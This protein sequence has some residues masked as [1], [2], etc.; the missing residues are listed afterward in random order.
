MPGLLGGF[1]NY[2]NSFYFLLSLSTAFL[3][4]F[5]MAWSKKYSISCQG[6]N[7]FK[8]KLNENIK[9]YCKYKLAK[10][11]TQKDYSETDF[12]NLN[13][14]RSKFGPYLAGLIEGD[15][16]IAV[17]DPKNGAA[18][19]KY[20]P[21]II[22]VFKKADLPLANYLQ[23]ITKCGI[24][25][26]KPERGYVL[27]QIQDI[28]SVY[29]IIYIINGFMRTPK[30]EALNKAIVWLNN[31][32]TNAKN[33]DN[34]LKN[35]NPRINIII[36]KISLL[37]IKPL[38][39]TPIEN[40]GWLAG[41]TESKSKFLIQI[42]KMRRNK[43]CRGFFKIKVKAVLRNIK[44]EPFFYSTYSS[45]FF[46]ISECF[47]T[48]FFTS[49]V[50]SQTK[51]SDLELPSMAAK[52]LLEKRESVSQ[53]KN[54]SQQE[55][56]Q[57]IYNFIIVAH[58]INNLEIII[59]YFNKFPFLG[60]SQKDYLNWRTEILKIIKVNS[61]DKTNNPN[62]LAVREQ[63]FNTSKINRPANLNFN[64]G[65]HLL[66]L[67]G[68]NFYCTYTDTKKKQLI[69]KNSSSICKS[70]VIWGDNLTSC[71][72]LGKYTKL[73]SNMV[74]IPPFQKSIVI[75]LLLS[76]GYLNIASSTTLN[77]RLAFKQSLAHSDYFFYVFNFL[78]HYCSSYPIL[79]VGVRSGNK[80]YGL[81]FQTRT[82]PCFK[83]LYRMFYENKVKR[84]PNNIYE[85]LTP[86]ALAHWIMGDGNHL[87]QG[88]QLCTDS[89][90]L[91]DTVKL[92]NV[93]IILYNFK[94]TIHKAGKGYRIYISRKSLDSLIKMVK[95]YFIPAMYYKLGIKS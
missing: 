66:N 94:V 25:L 91:Q 53:G 41:F 35:G 33:I 75:G 22:I 23:N 30:I 54:T 17:H 28:V 47:Q 64:V 58:K 55:I 13:L 34:L 24:V 92:M 8:F 29:T 15:G 20:N 59:N 40:N 81:L 18:T 9:L 26:I 77:A 72:G 65:S 50:Q 56:K 78:S 85:I 76:D 27:W 1:G 37:E 63:K 7:L 21:K 36:N 11:S 6:L 52:V 57:K 48:G 61:G 89:F 43:I 60:N 49:P 16:T 4:K 12:F 67:K 39:E 51:K 70:L 45:L 68:V 44:Q 69:S 84:L 5:K 86:V 19:I 90:S 93:L 46:Q 32:I 79:T 95:P 14:L 73:I 82:L 71:I 87:S 62:G 88:I 42:Q 38:D 83:E 10:F 31:Y 2:N 3:K 74:T 80:F